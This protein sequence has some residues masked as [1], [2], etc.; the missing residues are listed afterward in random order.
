[1]K[2]YCEFC[3]QIKEL[4]SYY[5]TYNVPCKCCGGSYHYEEVKACKDCTPYPPE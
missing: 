2:G 5:Y 3:G 1:M 4:T